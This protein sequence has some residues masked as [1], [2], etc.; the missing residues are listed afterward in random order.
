MALVNKDQIFV[1]TTGTLLASGTTT[2]LGY[3]Q[4]G[5]FDSTTYV[6]TT[7]PTFPTNRA[8]IIAQGTSDEPLNVGAFQGNSTDKTEAIVA[9]NITAW[10]AKAAE[11]AQ[12]GIVALGYDG[13]DT[14][15]T[16]TL[17]KGEVKK[18]WIRLSGTAVDYLMGGTSSYIKEEFTVA[19]DCVGDC[20]DNCGDAEDCE[21][22]QDKVIK[23]LLE[24]KVVGGIPLINDGTAS[25]SNG[26]LQAIALTECTTPSGYPTTSCNK[27]NLVLTDAGNAA[28]LGAVQAQYPTY[29]ITRISRVGIVST[30]E[31]I[32]CDGLTPSAFVANGGT[33]IPD[34]TDCPS[35]Y[36]YIA[37]VPV[38]EV[39]RPDTNTAAN[40]ATF[41]TD[42]GGLII[43]S[44]ASRISYSGGQSTYQVYGNAATTLAQMQTRAT[45]VGAGDVVVQSGTVQ[46][47]CQG[48]DGDTTAWT[49][50]GNCTKA[51]KYYKIT[52]SSNDC[53]TCA[54][55][56]TAVQ[57]AY[58]EI[59]TVT[60][61]GTDTDTCTCKF[62]IAILSENASCVDCGDEEYTFKTPDP[63]Q[64][65]SWVEIAGTPVGTGC[66]CGV[67]LTS[68][69]VSRK[70]AE[71]YFDQV[72][73]I[74]EPIF[75]EI[76]QFPFDQVDYA[77]LCDTDWDVT[78]LQSAKYAAGHGSFIAD[79]EK[80]S[81]YY[82]NKPW[83][84]DPAERNVLGYEFNT[85]F[86]SYYDQYILSY[87][88]EQPKGYPGAS[89]IRSFEFS[90]FFP[91]GSGTD[92]ATAINA[93]L[94]SSGSSVPPV[95]V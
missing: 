78:V 44:S 31:L 20:T 27:F 72:P 50:V 28:A 54:T 41:K 6:A 30:Y 67:K 65:T 1:A 89:P 73:Y 70:R 71:C 34:C 52:L 92:F 95:S 33:L 85:V 14:T 83:K 36:N 18:F 35:G 69:Y 64:G 74:T 32:D 7:T 63:Y 91:I 10:R 37:E 24:R 2:N 82:F 16:L 59:G 46:N 23:A 75:I 51:T 17:N 90:L 84:T 66:V 56:L 58:S 5:V 25:K 61:Q 12:N 38:F 57:A 39:S 55:L 93:Y 40:L 19:G 53:L 62:H 48:N 26:L 79:F 47:I 15:K 88:V 11:V 21:V 13:I 4:I 29:T 8:I 60:L 49:D 68:A 76:S 81:K 42:F 43:L 94:A 3:G 87:D 77:A 22:V 9:K 45:A 86:D 80:L